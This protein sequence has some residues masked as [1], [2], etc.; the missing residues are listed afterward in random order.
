MEQIANSPEQRAC[1]LDLLPLSLK[2]Y[3]DPDEL[4]EIRDAPARTRCPVS[5]IEIPQTANAIF[6]VWLE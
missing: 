6:Y 2:E 1:G 5:Q 4:R 3:A